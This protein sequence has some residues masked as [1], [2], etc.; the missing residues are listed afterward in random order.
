MQKIFL[1]FGMIATAAEAAKVGSEIRH[2]GR[3]YNAYIS[4]VGLSAQLLTWRRC[5][6]SKLRL[7]N[8]SFTKCVDRF[9]K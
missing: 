6:T 5:K 4:F 8:F 2:T 3:P 1:A 9:E 7:I